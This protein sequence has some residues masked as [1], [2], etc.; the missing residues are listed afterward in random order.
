M[1]GL[2]AKPAAP[3]VEALAR[4]W[5]AGRP[6]SAEEARC[7]AP[8]GDAAAY[9][10]QTALGRRLGW[11]PEGRPRGWKLA[12]GE[13]P[14]AAPIPAGLYQRSPARMRAPASVAGIEVEL[15]VRL[16]RPLAAG[17]GRQEAE[18][19]VGETLAVIECFDVRAEAWHT[20]PPAFLL[21]DLQMHG[22]LVTGA[23]V[24]GWVHPARLSLEAT[25]LA[26]AHDD[27]HHPLDDPLALLPWLAIHAAGRGWPLQA[28]DLIAT[29]SWCGMF[30]VPP[31]GGV[32]A[33]FDGVGEVAL[34]RPAGEAT[35]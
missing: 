14:K 19:A 10:V 26:E 18:A 8:T 28:G 17:A 33:R 22:G 1:V 25:W 20:L 3:L 13:P 11:W 30:E 23:G 16:S 32:K 21:A 15:A 4:A 29:G 7:L 12:M 35:R 9:A 27:W 6:L 2:S 24:S 5:Q 31:G 34:T